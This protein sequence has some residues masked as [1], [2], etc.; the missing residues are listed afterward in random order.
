MDFE[1]LLK[2]L[3]EEIVTEAKVKF[4][5]EG[6]IIISDM[7]DYLDSSKEKLKKWS[8]LF[9]SGAIDKEELAW[10][11]KSQKSLLTLR[12]LAKLGVNKIKLG[13][14]KNKVISIVFNKLVGIVGL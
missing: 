4:G 6:K 12:A 14:F 11:L 9:V 3:K 1:K 10:L 8:L 2:E 7:Q 5:A 13:H